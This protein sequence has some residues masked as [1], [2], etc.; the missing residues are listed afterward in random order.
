MVYNFKGDSCG[1]L[2]LMQP[3]DNCVTG[4]VMIR[5]LIRTKI[6][7]HI[8][9]VMSRGSK[10]RMDLHGKQQHVVFYLYSKKYNDVH[11]YRFNTIPTVY[12]LSREGRMTIPRE[13]S[14][15]ISLRTHAC[16]HSVV[17]LSSVCIC[18]HGDTC[19]RIVMWGITFLHNFCF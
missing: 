12:S 7:K 6:M 19:F 13:Q 4:H 3:N 1:D 9:D 2:H 18:P 17:T 11:S 14:G 5:F 15:F 8:S 10:S 16:I